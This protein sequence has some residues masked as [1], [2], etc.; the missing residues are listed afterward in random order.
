MMGIYL[1]CCL[2]ALIT[3]LCA[4]VGDFIH[5]A[6]QE[7]VIRSSELIRLVASFIGTLFAIV[8]GLLISSSYST[9]NN[10]QADFNAMVTAT[11]NIDLLLKLY[12]RKSAHLREQLLHMIERVLLRYWPESMTSAEVDLSYCTLE[13]D[14]NIII[15]I[16]NAFQCIENVSRDDINAI[17]QYSNQFVST[18]SNIIRSL[19][20][21]APSLLLVIVFGWACLLF[22]LY[23]ILGGA[24]LFGIFFLFLGAVTIASANFLILEL[25]SPYQGM[26]KISS[27]ALHLLRK[28]IFSELKR[29]SC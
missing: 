17:R 29:D 24:N 25:T 12:G 21:Q 26:F 7:N 18:Q 8:L 16:N 1:R 10:H 22:F 9:F 11:A 3:F 14:A 13:E 4:L 27:E 19:A 6:F 23:G 2:V 28:S 15:D 20:N 5:F